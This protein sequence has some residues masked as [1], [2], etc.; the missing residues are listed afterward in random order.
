[1]TTGQSTA[2]STRFHV[3][4]AAD[5]PLVSILIPCYN[6]EA[7]VAEC[8]ESALA[9]TY[10]NMEIIVVDDGSRDGSAEV[11]RKFGT[12]VT[13]HSAPNKGANATRNHLTSLARGEWLQYLDADDYL[14]PGKVASQIETLRTSSGE[15][16]KVYAPTMI[17]Y[18]ASPERDYTVLVDD[19]DPILNFIRWSGFSTIS[20]LFRR[21]AVLAVGGWK[22]DQPCCQEHELILRLLL[23]GSR[24]ALCRT[25]GA[26]Y[27][28]HGPDTIS[29]RDPGR[30]MRIRMSLTNRL[31]DYLRSTGKLD[32]RYKAALFVSRMEAARGLFQADPA[33][34]CELFAKAME[35][36]AYWSERSPA[37][38]ASYRWV[39]QL[40]GFKAAETV[41]SRMRRMGK[42]NEPQIS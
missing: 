18:D 11:V 21:R 40:I 36:G 34:A 1:V 25:P 6:A 14:L 42:R 32:S 3:N 13:L 28:K 16:D 9:Q 7:W 29:T 17:H 20:G 30:V 22:E 38:P 2:K 4:A 35:N 24:F 15:I 10:A 5:E 8:I 12:R 23:A 19:E 39:A 27:R 37:L 31:A 26:V 41:A 33:G